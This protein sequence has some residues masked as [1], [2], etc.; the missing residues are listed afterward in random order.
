M[1]NILAIAQNTFR[2][3]IRDRILYVIFVFAVLMLVASLLAGSISLDQDVKVIK[4][5][6]LAS[7]FLF[8]TLMA[9]FIGTNLVYKE[10]DKRTIFLIL[11]KP[12]KRSEFIV[13]KFAGLALTMLA[14]IAIMTIFFLALVRI[15]TG[16][17]DPLLLEA[18]ALNY[19]ELLIIIALTITFSAFTAPL[20]SAVYAV[21]VFLIGHS[22]STIWHIAISSSNVFLKYTLEGVYY[23]FPN[24]EKFN[25]RN[26]VSYGIGLSGEQALWSIGYA[27]IYVVFLLFMAV[28]IL[29]R[30]EF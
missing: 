19:I 27:L 23:I 22:M 17:W 4:D 7:I 29:R 13:G 20:S 5:F 12:I 18:I 28:V 24:L 3:S 25:V 2:E 8:S 15:K 30:Q 1:R 11:S 9:V 6:G 14:I 10:I 26:T 16:G 21:L